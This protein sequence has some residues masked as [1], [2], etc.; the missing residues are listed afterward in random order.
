MAAVAVSSRM[1]NG[2]YNGIAPEAALVVVKAFAGDGQSTYADVLR[3]LD[4]VLR[5]RE[6]LSIRV[7]NLSFSAPP[8]SHYWDDP[9][10]QAVMRLWQAGIVVVASAGNTG[11]GP[12]TVG[13][14]G[15]LPYIIT[16]GAM[17]D[18]YTPEDRSDDRMTWFS[19]VGPT[20]EGFVKP[21]LVAPGGHLRGLMSKNASIP[22]SH[23]QFHDGGSYFAMSGTS[24]SAAVVSGV[25]ALM[26][27]VDPTLTP[28]EVKFR[29]QA[30][31]RPAVDETGAVVISIF[32]Q[33]AGLV[34]AWR[35]VFPDL[36]GV[37]NRGLD[38]AADLDGRMHFG[39]R[40]TKYAAANYYLEGLDGVLWNDSVMWHD[41]FTWSDSLTEPMWVNDWV[42]TALVRADDLSSPT[43]APTSQSVSSAQDPT[44][45]ETAAMN[46]ATAATSAARA[47]KIQSL[48]SAQAARAAER[49]AKR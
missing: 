40:A 25:V 36:T 22:T 9:L 42:V 43:A 33:G 27:Q 34:D 12:M 3:G 35:A 4:W 38:L 37:A 16:V 23:P 28:D 24:Q 18:V 48:S 49:A 10:N 20:H 13:V 21:D 1:I 31:S 26:L 8:Q 11:P 29:L 14:P 32:Q 44:A 47:A 46:A 41:G 30:S 39:G 19:A 17:T 2:E 6:R 15:N 45:A 5:N 7:L